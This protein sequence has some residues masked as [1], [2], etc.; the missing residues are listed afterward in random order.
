MLRR[1]ALLI[2]SVAACSTNGNPDLLDFGTLPDIPLPSDL[3]VRPGDLAMAPDLARTFTCRGDDAPGTTYKLVMNKVLLPGAS[4]SKT[5]VYDFDGDGRP[6]NQLKN[7]LNTISLSG[8]DIQ[9]PVDDAVSSGLIINLLSLTSSAVDNSSCVGVSLHQG[10]PGGRPKFDG[11][12]TFNPVSPTGSPLAGTLLA[13][14]LKTVE[15]RNLKPETE[16]QFQLQL[17]L[18]K[19]LLQ[20]PLRGVHVE[21]GFQTAGPFWQ[22]QSGALYGA[23]AK[24]DL[25]GKLVPAI[26]DQLTVL[27]HSDPFSS[28]AQTIIALFESKTD[29]VSVT[30]CMTASR[31]CRTSPATCVILPEEVQNS[32]VG[33]VLA[34]DIEVLD[35]MGQWKP[36]A[37]G[38]K[39][40]A[41][42]VG[43]GFTA[44]SASY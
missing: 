13:T 24:K 25:D 2:C 44:I 37:G 19:T 6:E 16:S 43:L 7:V 29:P 42:S 33:N 8:L 11:T 21:G 34:P 18:G 35:S 3:A 27:I 4:G 9:T 32:V 1:L 17:S 20:L 10:K 38:K 39:Y 36:V 28:T 15:S 14:Q 23:I 26:A 40:N 22:I 31:C 41:M 30:K 12:D 5:Y